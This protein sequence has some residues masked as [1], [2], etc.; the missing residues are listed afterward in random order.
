MKC[1]QCE[2]PPI[3]KVQIK[4]HDVL[5]CID[6]YL[7]YIQVE[8][9]EMDQL[10]RLHNFLSEQMDQSVGYILTSPKIPVRSTIQMGDVI[11]HNLKIENSN[12]GL[13]NTGNIGTVDAAITILNQTGE[14]DI[15]LALQKLTEAIHSNQETTEDIKQ[16]IL[17]ILSLLA[18]EATTPKE[19][20]KSKVIG[21]LLVNLATL[22]SGID[23]LTQLWNQY[24]PLLV[25]FFK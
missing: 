20:R 13:V 22:V 18:T 10:V 21:K 19:N 8:E 7:K 5:F 17:E 14:H 12:I 3:Y 6:H 9:I 25:S 24:G 15:A 16:E 2:K 23:A 11:L 1:Y 4:G